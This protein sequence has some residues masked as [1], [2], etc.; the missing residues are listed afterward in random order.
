M[1]AIK[2]MK[3]G[4]SRIGI[5]ICEIQSHVFE[6]S[7]STMYTVIGGG[8]KV[9]VKDNGNLGRSWG[10]W[11]REMASFVKLFKMITLVT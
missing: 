7:L 2:E 6:S 8:H 3:M 1:E 9:H 5:C 11:R 4:G 10:G